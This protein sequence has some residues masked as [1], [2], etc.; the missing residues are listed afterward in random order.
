[1]GKYKVTHGQ[2]LYDVALHIYG[3]IEGITDLLINNEALSLSTQLKAGDELTYSDNYILNAEVVTSFS[4]SGTIPS[5]GERGVYFKEFTLPK[6]VEIR[7]SQKLA[8][9]SFVIAGSGTIEIDWGDNSAPQTIQL[10]DEEMAVNHIFDSSIGTDRKIRFY[11]DCTLKTL[12]ISG[13][14]PTALYILRPL[15]LERLT[16]SK[17]TIQLV[18]LPMLR[19]LFRLTL[20]DVTTANLLPLVELTELME[21]NLTKHTY[22]QPTIDSFLMALVANYGNRRNCSIT[23]ETEPSGEYREP[24][25][26]ANERYVIT[27]GMEAIWVI[28]HEPAWNEAGAWQFI[29][30]NTTYKY[31]QINQPDL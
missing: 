27:S 21:L 20:A 9:V 7:C 1:M 24:Q 29:I 4:S 23:M 10:S 6:S 2:C 26:D 17:C 25:R 22:T 18:S 28:T 19:G 12:D 16:I 30:N 5:T 8:S 13:M 31:E 3:S 15:Y 11:M 14:N